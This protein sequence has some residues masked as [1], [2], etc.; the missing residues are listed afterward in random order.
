MFFSSLAN[1]LPSRL[2]AERFGFIG[3][4][5]L[6]MLIHSGTPLHAADKLDIVP[7][8]IRLVFGIDDNGM[9]VVSY[10][11]E[12][13]I[14]NRQSRAIR[15]VSVHWLNSQ[16]EVIGNSDA[17]CGI[18]H[19]GIK[20]SQS[21]ACRRTVQKIGGRLLDRLGQEKW[22]DIINSELYNFQ[23][24]RNCAIIGYRFGE[25]AVNRY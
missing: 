17:T 15:G 21:G 5:M 18:N 6:N 11:L 10:D 13:Q 24:V 9:S 2:V 23:T 25:P 22:T 14:N 16:S 12:M 7:C 1:I 3:L 19:D 4:A 20:L 8:D